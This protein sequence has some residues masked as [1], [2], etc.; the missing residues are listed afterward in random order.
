MEYKIRAFDHLFT[1]EG[2]SRQLLENH[3]T[4]YKG[5]VASVNRLDASLADL[6]KR[7]QAG[8]PEFAEMKRRFGWEFNGMRLHELY[9][10]N[11][12]SG[13]VAFSENSMLAGKIKHDFGSYELWR[14][15]FK[16]TGTMRGIGWTLLCYD[17]AADRLFNV[18]TNEHDVGLLAGCPILLVLDV[19]EHAYILDYGLKR[20][21]YI[22]AFLAALDHQETE[23]R[24]R[25]A[26]VEHVV[27]A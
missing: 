23:N 5:Y 13:G 25:Q 20:A 17:P 15:D 14:K 11:M 10:G 8:S 24:F 12:K 27:V 6:L 18:W 22:E 26:A 3:F 21:D 16:S 4:L 19:F 9:F 2:F 1:T 7:D